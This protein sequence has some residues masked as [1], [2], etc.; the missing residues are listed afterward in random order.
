[1]TFS[2]IAASAVHMRQ[3]Y[4]R[5]AVAWLKYSIAYIGISSSSYA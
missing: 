3:S 4:G 2:Y 5:S 1:M